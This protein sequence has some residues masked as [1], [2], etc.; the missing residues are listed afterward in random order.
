VHAQCGCKAQDREPAGN[1]WAKAATATDS[2][3]SGQSSQEV[4]RAKGSYHG[5]KGSIVDAQ[6]GRASGAVA[7]TT[8]APSQSLDQHPGED[9]ARPHARTLGRG[10]DDRLP[11]DRGELVHH[12]RVFRSLGRP[13]RLPRHARTSARNDKN[14]TWGKVLV[15]GGESC[16]GTRPLESEAGS[17]RPKARRPAGSGRNRWSRASHAV[18]ARGAHLGGRK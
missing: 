13:G 12:R 4:G 17:V 9:P 8:T 1:S 2:G 11:D 14:Q 3:E 5:A 10:V 16:Q 7:R 15:G 18:N 6:A